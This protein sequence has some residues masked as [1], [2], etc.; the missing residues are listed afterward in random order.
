MMIYHSSMRALISLFLAVL[1]I[2]VCL[3]QSRVD[4]LTERLETQNRECLAKDSINEVNKL[5]NDSLKAILEDYWL[6]NKSDLKTLKR[7][8]VH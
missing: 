1:L 7:I 2:V 4:K 6:V 3:Y 5:D 8:N